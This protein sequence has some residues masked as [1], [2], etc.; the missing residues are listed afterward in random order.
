[1]SILFRCDSSSK[2]GS[3]HL[4]RSINLAKALR[5]YV[6]NIYFICADLDGNLIYKFSN[7]FKFYKIENSIQKD[8]LSINFKFSEIED[9][10]NSFQI[11]S[12]YEREIPDWIIVDHYSIGINWQNEFNKL[13]D[14]QTNFNIKKSKYLFIDDIADRELNADILVNPS[15]Y[16]FKVHNPYLFLSNKPRKILLGPHYSILNS[17]YYEKKLIKNKIGSKKKIVIYFGAT[18]LYNI[19]NI[20]S[21]I[22]INDYFKDFD[23]DYILPDVLKNNLEI[24]NNVSGHSNIKLSYNLP[25]LKSALSNADYAIGSGGTTTWERLI[26][27]I[28]TL[29]IT[30]ASNQITVSKNLHEH[31]FLVNLTDYKSMNKELITE[32]IKKFFELPYK[33][34]NPNLII[35]EYGTK[36]VVGAILKPQLPLKVREIIEEDKFLLWRWANDYFVRINSINQ[37]FITIEDHM[38]WFYKNLN[39]KNQLH[40]I[41]N[42]NLNIPIGQCRFDNENDQFKVSIS[43][44]S[45]FRNKKLSIDILDIS[46]SYFKKQYPNSTKLFAL[47]KKNNISSNKLFKKYGFKLKKSESSKELNIYLLNI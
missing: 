19:Y 27:N 2:I 7:E 31:N 44:D 34:R 8:I 22:I 30:L 41:I 35:D 32:K 9:A 42:D 33:L 5:K 26:L 12:D 1:M 18:N 16:G 38:N 29:V 6:N 43:I 47:V 4:Y 40:L 28:P 37:N 3:G 14:I 11:I 24:R 45:A 39:N 17:E 15:F 10:T 20:F 23:I 13:V 36:R 25:S 21:E 46:I